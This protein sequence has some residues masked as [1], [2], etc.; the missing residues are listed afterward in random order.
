[1]QGTCVRAE[2]FTS[3][4]A[5]FRHNVDARTHKVRERVELVTSSVL[6]RHAL[7]Q[8]ECSRLKELAAMSSFMLE[9]SF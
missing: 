7:A 8:C 4:I 1:M 9:W 2:R 6:Y 3:E 5:F